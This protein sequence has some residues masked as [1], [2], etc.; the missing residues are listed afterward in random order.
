MRLSGTGPER[1]DLPALPAPGD[2]AEL[3]EVVGRL[4]TGPRDAGETRSLVLRLGRITAGRVRQAGATALGTGRWLGDLVIDVAPHVPVRDLATLTAHHHGLTGEALADALVR[5][6][7][8]TTAGIGAAVGTVA[9]A[10]WAFA[11]ILIA[12]PLEV[13]VETVAVAAVEVKL[14]GE[15]HAVYGVPVPGTGT[16]RAFGLVVAWSQRRGVSPLSPWAL[17]TA[18]LAASRAGISRRAMGRLARNLG[19]LAPLMV[20]AFYGAR[21][22]RNQTGKLADRVRADLRARGAQARA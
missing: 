15:L 6:A 16:A 13:V 17:S 5:N 1:P 22:N 21:S 8:R 11:P 2:D 10:Q 18:A 12:V 7:A 9:A 19:G 20:G 14:L 4:T 3:A